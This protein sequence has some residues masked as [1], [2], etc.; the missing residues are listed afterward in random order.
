MNIDD[1]NRMKLHEIW[2][3]DENHYVMCVVGG[4]IYI[5]K[6]GQ[7]EEIVQATQFVPRNYQIIGVD[8]NG[9]KK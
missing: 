1:L 5:F 8:G 3:F 7:N 2:R 6:T 9:P 4:W